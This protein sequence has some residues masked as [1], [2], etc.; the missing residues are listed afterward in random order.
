MKRDNVDRHAIPEDRLERFMGLVY[1]LM[2][3]FGV[4][5][6]PEVCH[7]V[8]LLGQAIERAVVESKFNG[9]SSQHRMTADRR[10]FI[11]IFKNRYVSLT[12]LEYNRTITG[13]DGKMIGQ[14]IGSL[15]E[16]GFE[17][18][19]YLAWLFDDFLSENPKFCPP[20]IKFACGSLAIE[21]F[22]FLNRDKIKQKKEEQI[23]KK[24]S[25][26]LIARA[27]IL[28]RTF[29]NDEEMKKKI[30]EVLRGYRDG[31][32]MLEKMRSDIEAIE[33]IARENPTSQPEQDAI[34]A[35]DGNGTV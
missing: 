29:S 27:R 17:V 5:Q 33:K 23:R 1:S 35:G 28:I 7:Y 8:E 11:V 12:D 34:Q 4:D 31:S 15:T 16:K 19:E 30:A 24:L 10:K 18:D 25:L 3:P 13:I 20:T 32:I 6:V 2:E 14:L 9:G 22:L 26:D 21:K